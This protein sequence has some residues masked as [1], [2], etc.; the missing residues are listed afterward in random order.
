MPGR[1]SEIANPKSEMARK[2]LLI[3]AN[4][5]KPEA[6]GQIDALRDWFAA[7]GELVA[8][9]GVKEPLPAGATEADLCVV[10][11][12]DGTLLSAVRSLA[13]AGVPLLGVNMGKLGFLADFDVAHMQRHLGDVLAGRIRPVPRMILDAALRKCDGQ[14]VQSPAA[15]DVAISAGEP[16]RMIG[17]R[18]TQGEQRIAQ[19]RGDGVVVAAPGGST[20]YNLSAGGPILAPALRAMVITPIAPH[21]LSLRPIVVG[22]DEPIEIVAETVNPGTAVLIDG[23]IRFPLC[24]GETVTVRPADEPARIVPHPGRPFFHT[25]AEKLHWGRSPH[26]EG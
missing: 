2:R 5:D 1:Q 12:G 25:L 23:Q 8:V 22:P 11:G 16:F 6:V 21:T 14:L 19:Y 24:R 4:K 9:A 17:V 18:V 13:G 10:F 3:L 15:N 20:G 26:H 7:Q